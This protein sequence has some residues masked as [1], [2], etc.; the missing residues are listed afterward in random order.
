MAD[1]TIT[2]KPGTGTVPGHVWDI[3]VAGP[4]SLEEVVKAVTPGDP[5]DPTQDPAW[6]VSSLI[7]RCVK[8]AVPH[9]ADQ[10]ATTEPGAVDALISEHA[11]KFQQ[12]YDQRT[13]GDH[14][15]TGALAIFAYDL[16]PLL[17]RLSADRDTETA[18]RPRLLSGDIPI[19]ERTPHGVW[20]AD[21]PDPE[22]HLDVPCAGLSGCDDC[23]AYDELRQHLVE[24]VMLMDQLRQDEVA[25]AVRTAEHRGEIIAHLEAE[26]ETLRQALRREETD[27]ALLTD[28][29]SEMVLEIGGPVPEDRADALSILQNALQ[30]GLWLIAEARWNATIRQA[31][32]RERD[33]ARQDR[34]EAL[35]EADVLR[36]DAA[37]YYA[38]LQAIHTQL[39]RLDESGQD[40]TTDTIRATLLVNGVENERRAASLGG[41]QA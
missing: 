30:C 31:V 36:E 40:Y 19:T 10:P 9:L 28:R 7:Q 34:D 41:E 16:V 12:V 2:G 1:P 33:R 32:E 3:L 8:A 25:A 29:L 38:V 23:R 35:N 39:N 13:A 17:A 4:A 37:R 5:G 22:P 14:T 6:K 20:I 15:F 18:A 26:T 27:S 11:A 21:G 24:Q